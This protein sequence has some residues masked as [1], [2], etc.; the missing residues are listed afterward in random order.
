[1]SAVIFYDEEGFSVVSAAGSAQVQYQNV[2]GV[3]PSEWEAMAA[4][5]SLCAALLAIAAIIAL[6]VFKQS[7]LLIGAAAVILL[8]S[9]PICVTTTINTRNGNRE[10]QHN[11][12]YDLQQKYGAKLAKDSDYPYGKP[13]DQPFKYTLIQSD[14]TTADVMVK[15]D[16]ATSEPFIL[17]GTNK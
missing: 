16:K 1:M 10:F 11:M 14:G 6:L 3:L 2:F 5:F 4:M 13:L 17:T 8:I 9:L 7:K 12:N 15:F